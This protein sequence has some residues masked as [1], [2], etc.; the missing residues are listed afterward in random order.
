M[1][2]AT[3]AQEG[4]DAGFWC[5]PTNFPKVQLR[6]MSVS[7]QSAAIRKI[8]SKGGQKCIDGF[9]QVCRIAV[10][11]AQREHAHTVRHAGYE[12]GRASTALWFEASPTAG[13]FLSRP[14]VSGV[15]QMVSAWPD[16]GV[17]VIATTLERV[18]ADGDG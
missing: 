8:T 17:V 5:A 14:R 15:F 16:L 18:S 6:V 10:E 11:G 2:T 7:Q 12:R 9:R 4:G 1:V 3:K 13:H